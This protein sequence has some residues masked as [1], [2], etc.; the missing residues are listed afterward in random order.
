M[1][2]SDLINCG[3]Y[4]FTPDIFTAIH[5]VYINQEGRGWSLSITFEKAQITKGLCYMN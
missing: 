1:Q 5:D 2:V 3:V 4:V